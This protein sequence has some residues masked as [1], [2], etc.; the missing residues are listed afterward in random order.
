MTVRRSKVGEVRENSSKSST[1]NQSIQMKTERIRTEILSEDILSDSEKLD[2]MYDEAEYVYF[3][4][5]N[6]V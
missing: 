3:V 5:L 6:D 2:G 1:G 4:K